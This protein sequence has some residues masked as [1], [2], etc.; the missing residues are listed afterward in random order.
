MQK[1]LEKQFKK[2]AVDPMVSPEDIEETKKLFEGLFFNKSSKDKIAVVGIYPNKSFVAD[3]MDFDELVRYVWYHTKY[4]KQ[5]YFF[6]EGK[7]LNYNLDEKT[8]KTVSY[9]KF[10]IQTEKDYIQFEYN[11]VSKEEMV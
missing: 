3:T 9:N 5:R 8:E 4:S 7:L 2:L 1:D 6:V 10:L 11:N